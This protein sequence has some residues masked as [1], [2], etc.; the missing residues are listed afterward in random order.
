MGIFRQILL[1]EKNG[2][3]IFFQIVILRAQNFSKNIL[4]QPKEYQF[5]GIAT[6]CIVVLIVHIYSDNRNPIM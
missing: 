2:F 5:F 6:D 3:N 1:R 4:T